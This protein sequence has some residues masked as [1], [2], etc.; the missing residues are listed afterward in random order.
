MTIQPVD[1]ATAKALGLPQAKGALIGGLIPGQPAEKA[2]IEPGD[3]ILKIDNTEI[4]NPEELQQVI[5][6]KKPGETVTALVWRDGRSKNYKIQ[7]MERGAREQAANTPPKDGEADT[8]SLGL[9]VRPVSEQETARL[10]L[11]PGQGLVIAQLDPDKL[12]A[13]AGLRRGDVILA[14]GR[15]PVR[16]VEDFNKDVEAMFKRQ[17]AVI[18]Q[19]NRGGNT[20]IASIETGK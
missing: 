8:P 11:N 2:G 7:L 4:N 15:K 3:V 12:G 18:L 20:F 1:A 14:V 9:H 19:I 13:K 6:R 5:M 16:G 17:G 10:R